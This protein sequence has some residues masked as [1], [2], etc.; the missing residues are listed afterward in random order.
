MLRTA[1][2]QAA[3]LALGIATIPA[4]HGAD[5][6]APLTRVGD[7]YTVPITFGGKSAPCMVD[8]GADFVVIPAPWVHAGAGGWVSGKLM[9]M[10][11]AEGTTR[12]H[13]S[14]T[15][16][17]AVGSAEL[18]VPVLLGDAGTDCLLGQSFLA[19]FRSVTFDYAGKRLILGG[20]S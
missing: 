6:V 11:N 12:A 8:T 16:T 10:R 7:S 17:L 2:I 20:T 1:L 19:R 9:Y 5:A 15:M 18:R 14:G 3:S 13:H 4:A